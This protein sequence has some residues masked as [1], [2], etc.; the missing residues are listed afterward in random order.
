MT[1]QK[2][3]IWLTLTMVLAFTVIT[4]GAYTRLTNAG[5]GC[6]DWP[7][8]YGQLTAPSSPGQVTLAQS[9]Y[10]AQSIDSTKAWTEMIHRYVAGSLGL[11]IFI[12]AGLSIVHQRR[13]Q[14]PIAV[15][16]ALVGLVIFQ[17]LLGMWTVTLKLHPLVVMAH[18]LGGLTLIAGLTWWRATLVQL[19]NPHGFSG[20]DKRW[21]SWVLIGL[22]LLVGQIALGG[23][24][25]A[26]YAGIAC[27]GFP[28]CNGSWWPNWNW[29]AFKLFVPLGM[30]YEGGLLANS[31][32]VSIQMAHRVGA[33]IVVSYWSIL[34][35]RLFLSMK[36]PRIQGSLAVI[37]GLLVAQF[38]VGMINVLALL[39]L[40]A[41]T[42]HNGIAALLLVATVNLYLQI[43]H[44]SNR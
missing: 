39:P 29:E 26:N 13:Y 18:L 33:V 28:T 17:A 19:N 43:R 3:I 15:P 35:I 25:S 2:L 20:I 27:I 42:A 24:V 31:A 41:A 5:L 11:C 36:N 14:L 8:C 38:V 4:L 21:S 7:G 22:I 16:I 1:R 30:N 44:T 12:L 23:W 40:S 9:A 10:P 6:P 32:R 34:A 37:M